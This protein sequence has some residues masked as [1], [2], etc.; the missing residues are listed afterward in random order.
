MS[1]T[2]VAST[3]S[4]TTTKAGA[5]TKETTSEYQ[6]FLK[7]LTT[8]M[9][10]QDPLNPMEAS[11]F[12]VQLAT[13]S[14]VEQQVK[15][16]DL[17]NAILSGG[18][19]SGMGQYAGWIGMEAQVPAAAWYDGK[20]PLEITPTA[21]TGADSAKLIVTDST[22]RTVMST[23]VAANGETMSWD[24][25]GSDGSPLPAG[26]YSFN[27]Q[28]YAEGNLVGT[29]P[30]PVYAEVVETRMAS[31][32]TALLIL[33]GGAEVPASQASALRRME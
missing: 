25:V 18:A 3:A 16:N 23:E 31:D 6:T 11:D 17:L 20:T 28:S 22:G 29:A 7:M 30:V 32:G 12:A 2:P 27:L 5:S 4:P 10:N 14:G 1:V 15:T 33:E 24:G 8:Q 13:F 26:S 19:L 9:R 21:A